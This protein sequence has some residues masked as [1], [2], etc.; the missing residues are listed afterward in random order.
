MFRDGIA[1]V[2]APALAAAVLLAAAGEA[3]AQGV[4]VW[5]PRPVVSYYGV[6]PV[7]YSAPAG[8]SYYPRPAVSYYAPPAT[9]YPGAVTTTRRYGL[10][11]RRQVTTTYYPGAYA[12]P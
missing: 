12:Y 6:A 3:A 10:F 1:R 4:V 7:T 8:V 5:E 2:L 9:Y 11:G